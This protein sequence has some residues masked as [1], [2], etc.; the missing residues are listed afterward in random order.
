M[1]MNQYLDQQPAVLQTNLFD[2]YKERVKEM[3]KVRKQNERQELIN[4]ITYELKIERKHARWIYFTLLTNKEL[5]A[6]AD[7][8]LAWKVNPGALFSKNVRA[9][10]AEI[11]KTLQ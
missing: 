11:R 7:K 3:K 6:E 9:R 1:I 10:N 5:R 2:A 4:Q 8:A